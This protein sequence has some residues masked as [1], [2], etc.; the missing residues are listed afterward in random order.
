MK[1]YSKEWD[2]KRGM[3]KDEPFHNWD[4][5]GADMSRYAALSEKKM[6]NESQI[7][8]RPFYDNTDRIWRNE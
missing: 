2:E 6:I 7:L 5:H 3:Y 1:N 8:N 4:S